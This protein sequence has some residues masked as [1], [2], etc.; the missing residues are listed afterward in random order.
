MINIHDKKY[1]HRN[2]QE[3]ILRDLEAPPKIILLYGPRQVGKTTLVQNIVEKY[4]KKT[5]FVNADQEQYNDVFASRD[6]QKMLHLVEGYELLVID[7]A[8]RIENIGLGL[9]ILYDARPDIRILATGS[10][11][12]DLA[13]KVREPLTG[14]TWTYH[15]YPLAF[16]ELAQT[17]NHFELDQELET[18]LIYGLY[19][20]I[21]SFRGE[22]QRERLL[23]LSSSY[24][25][26]D[27]LEFEGIRYPRKIRDLLRLLAF[28]VGQEVSIH[29]LSQKLK[30]NANT[31]LRYIDLLEKSFVLFRLSAFSR[32]LRKEV[33]KKE[34]IYFYDLGI[35]NALVENFADLK[36]RN[37]VGQLWENFLL[38]ERIKKTSYAKQHMNR[39]FWRVYTGSEIDYIEEYDGVLH[40]YEFKYKK[41]SARLPK[42]FLETYKHVEFTCI[43]RE[44]YLDFITA[45]L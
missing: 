4:Q 20:E 41:S 23:E 40:A 12:L 24:L 17:K 44:N 18:A 19:P 27:I 8:Q 14:R 29:E 13:T 16:D 38:I 32:N 39:Y 28:Q 21:Y 3:D 2:I 33:G 10:S 22:R 30:I 7:E 9:K 43:S 34:K 26:R 6:L 42:T 1:I 45:G 37:D 25:Y 35:R 11:S 31:V 15:L 5:F 36:K